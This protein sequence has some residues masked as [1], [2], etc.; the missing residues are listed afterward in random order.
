MYLHLGKADVYAKSP[1]RTVDPASY[2][3]GAFGC[4]QPRTHYRQPTISGSAA[5]KFIYFEMN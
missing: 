1:L 5:D 2:A 3:A 4:R